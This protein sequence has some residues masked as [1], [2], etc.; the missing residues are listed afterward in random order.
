[1]ATIATA[2]DPQVAWNTN[3]SHKLE[4]LSAD[5]DTADVCIRLG[6]NNE[7]LAHK[8]ILEVNCGLLKTEDVAYNNK[9]KILEVWGPHHFCIF[10]YI[11]V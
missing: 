1:M 9:R 11:F 8:F 4:T 3:L 2:T 7:I 5:R 10:L 6:S